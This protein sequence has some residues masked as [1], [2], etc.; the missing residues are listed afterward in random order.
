MYTNV[1]HILIIGIV[2]PR[3][4]H[5]YLLLLLLSHFSRVRLCATPQLTARSYLGLHL[6]YLLIIFLSID[7]LCFP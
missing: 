3:N 1:S 5:S 2:Y 7:L 4:V 6:Y